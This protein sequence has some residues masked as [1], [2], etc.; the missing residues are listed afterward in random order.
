M[1]RKTFGNVFNTLFICFFGDSILKLYVFFALEINSIYLLVVLMR[2]VFCLVLIGLDEFL[3][4]DII[5]LM[6]FRMKRLLAF[7]G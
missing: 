6:L 5:F 4:T 3:Q 7:C 2:R 1:I